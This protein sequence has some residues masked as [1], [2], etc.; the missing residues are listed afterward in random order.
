MKMNWKY[1][2]VNGITILRIFLCP[3]ILWLLFANCLQPTAYCL[4]AAFLTD[5]LDGFLA[6]K[7]KVTSEFG[8]KIDSIADD[9]LFATAMICL[10]K[11]NPQIISDNAVMVGLLSVTYWVKVV[12]L[13]AR[14]KRFVS[15]FHTYLTKIAAVG[16]ALFFLHAMFFTASSFLFISAIVITMLAIVE[17]TVII[18]TIAKPS[19]NIRGI[20]FLKKISN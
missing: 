2:L 1:F 5:A 10:V 18:M 3:I 8:S 16:Q 6:R 19:Q 9:G 13:Y 14:H 12:L 11:I 7:L 4:L 20:F 15:G 17:E